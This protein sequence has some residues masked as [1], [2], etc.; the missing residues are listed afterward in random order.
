MFIC[1]W[2]L[3]YVGGVSRELPFIG[4]ASYL[5]RIVGSV[6]SDHG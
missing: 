5:M 1:Y 6:L 4:F 2:D 3:L